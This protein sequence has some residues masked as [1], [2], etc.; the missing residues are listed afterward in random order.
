MTWPKKYEA[1]VRTIKEADGDGETIDE[2]IEEYFPQFSDKKTAPGLH[3]CVLEMFETRVKETK[4]GAQVLQDLYPTYRKL[5]PNN[6][7]IKQRLSEV[8]KVIQ[9]NQDETL[10]KLSRLDKYWNIPEDERIAIVNAYKSD[11]KAKNTKKIQVDVNDVYEQMR[12]LIM[13]KDVYKKIAALLIATGARPVGLFAKNK[14][15]LIKDKPSWVKVS[16]LAKKRKEQIEAGEDVTERPIILF[17]PKFVI[18]EIAKIRN[19]FKNKI[20]LDKK[21][22]LAKDKNDTLNKRIIEA[23]PWTKEH[24]QKSSM[25]RKIYSSLSYKLFA[26]SKFQNENSWIQSV[27]GHSS[28]DLMTSFSYSY[29]NVADS[30]EEKNSEQIQ[31]QIEELRNQVQMLL[32]KK[33]EPDAVETAEPVGEKRSKPKESTESKFERLEK[34]YNATPKIS[35][36]ALRQKAKLGSSIVNAFLASKKEK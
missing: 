22:A 26:D 18:N 29:L 31:T 1:F 7:T 13:D 14:F 2:T 24:H 17:T 23:F 16:G 30:R 34:I 9:A 28:G 21:G 5:Y 12:E 19:H 15:E 8:R 4:E 25:M 32:T 6:K 27:L 3:E 36:S 20:L 10:Y 33:I 11:I 35:N